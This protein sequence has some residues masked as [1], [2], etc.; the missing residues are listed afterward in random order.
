MEVIIREEDNIKVVELIGEIDGKT[1]PVAQEQILSLA[2]PG[3]RLMLDMTKLE[4]MS[5]AG[6]RMMVLLYRKF[7]EHD[8]KIVLVGLNDGIRDT[9]SATGFINFFVLSDNYESGLEAFG[10]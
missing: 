9:M 2:S 5:S 4:Y 10:S 3:I 8:G 7:T 1:A 6:L